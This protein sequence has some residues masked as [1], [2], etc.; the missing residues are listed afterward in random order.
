MSSNPETSARRRMKGNQETL[1]DI[2]QTD[3]LP[4]PVADNSRG[5]A[6]SGTDYQSLPNVAMAMLPTPTA[7]AAKH[8][9]TPDTTANRFGSNLWDVPTLLPTPTVMDMG[10]GRTAEEW[11][12][13]R[14]A[15]KGK[16]QNGN[17]HGRSLEQETLSLLG[18]PTAAM[19]HRS[20]RGIRKNPNP[21]ELAAMVAQGLPIGGNTAPLSGDGSASPDPL[22]P[23]LS[24]G[25]PDDPDCLPLSWSG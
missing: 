18:T 23:P 12:S 6:Q 11:D 4:T 14:S 19:T 13:W 20:P 15:M 5:L 22:Q 21:R 2:V 9:E 17:G 16:H 8:G 7:Q 3:L 1:T 10:G 25:R 24:P